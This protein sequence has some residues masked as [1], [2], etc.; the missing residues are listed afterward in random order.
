VVIR[1]RAA[2]QTV[3]ENGASAEELPAEAIAAQEIGALC[4]FVDR[5]AFGERKAS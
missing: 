2:Y 5:F 1:S 4:T 3:L